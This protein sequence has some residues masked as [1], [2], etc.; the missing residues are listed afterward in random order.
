MKIL[1]TEHQHGFRKGHSCESALHE[2][3]SD[4]NLARD[5]KLTTM[6]LFIDFRKAFDTVDSNLLLTKLFHYGFDTG[7]LFLIADYFKNRSQI[8]KIGNNSSKKNTIS[9]GVPQGSILGP[10]LFLIF[11]NDLCF[12]MEDTSVKL[13]ADDTTIYNS[14][15]NF[16]DLIIQYEHDVSNI[17]EWCNKNRLDINWSKTFFMV[18]TNKRTKI[19]DSLII[20][21]HN[22]K[23]V[24]EF[25]LLGVMLDNK[26]NFNTHVSR[27][28]LSI[29]SKLFAIKRLFYLSTDVK[30]QFFKT[31]ILPYFDYCSTLLIYFNKQTIQR[32][33]NK[34]Y[35]CLH[36]LFKIDVSEF[37]DYNQLNTFLRDKYQISGFQHRLFHRL[38]VFSFK[39][40]NFT[41][42]SQINYYIKLFD[43]KLFR[44]QSSLYT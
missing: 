8:T 17:L 37:D 2:L 7:A 22:I 29:N 14:S 3:I 9:L 24:K 26:L 43:I 4:I 10:L 21:G 30:I 27:L 28:C 40:L 38:S 25:R 36:L 41:A 15:E 12:H 39:L 6:L 32:L 23:L 44:V 20:K 42:N 34:F 5:K 1:F 13:F 19:P 16:S 18:I 33:C 11:I 35:L 31:F